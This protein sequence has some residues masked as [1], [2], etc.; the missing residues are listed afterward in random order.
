MSR[1]RFC[2]KDGGSNYYAYI[3]LP[4]HYPAQVA[5]QGEQC[6]VEGGM[7]PAFTSL[8]IVPGTLQWRSWA[9]AVAVYEVLPLCKC[10][11]LVLGLAQDCAVPQ[12][13]RP[14]SLMTRPLK[15]LL[16]RR[17]SSLPIYSSCGLD[18]QTSSIQLSRLMGAC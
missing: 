12:R 5:M 7:A 3:Y 6:P 11:K 8:S 4:G 14:L 13:P 2:H 1:L 10:T 15:L 9:A 18:L 17:G 16:L